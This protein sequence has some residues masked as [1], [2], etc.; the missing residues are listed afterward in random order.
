MDSVGVG[1]NEESKEYGD[2]GANTLKHIGEFNN[3]IN[4]PTLESLGLGNITDI[5]GVNKNPAPL[6]SYGYMNE[7]SK[8]K[9]TLTGHWEMM[10]IRTLKPFKTFPD[11]FP[12]ELIDIC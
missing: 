11:G 2:F 4:L 1:S 3:G 5:K 6:A 10:G 7:L 12:K 9:D 8:G